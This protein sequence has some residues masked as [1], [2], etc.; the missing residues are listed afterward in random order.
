[1]AEAALAAP[2]AAA[3]DVGLGAVLHVVLARGRLALAEAAVADGLEV[4]A[5]PADQRAAS[6]EEH[7][8]GTEGAQH[9][10]ESMRIFFEVQSV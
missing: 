4:A 7:R 6:Q 5:E 10:R 9:A 2:P 3:V 1:L 8:C